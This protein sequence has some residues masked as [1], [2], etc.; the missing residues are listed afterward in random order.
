MGKDL[1]LPSPSPAPLNVVQR[2]F[3]KLLHFW[4][5]HN[6]IQALSKNDNEYMRQKVLTLDLFRGKKKMGPG[7]PNY[8]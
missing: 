5:A 3:Q 8:I 6:K 4:W 2:V 7:P 1:K